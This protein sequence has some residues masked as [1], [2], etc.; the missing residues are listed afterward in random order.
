L[1]AFFVIIA[2]LCLYR[3]KLFIPKSNGSTLI[4]D[5]YMSVEKS[6]SIKGIFILIVFLSHSDDYLT[7]SS[8]TL[9]TT[10]SLVMSIIG[11]AMVSMFLFYSGYGV[12]YSINKKGVGYVKSMPV[13]RI[14]KTLFNFD[15]VILLYFIVENILGNRFGIVK[16]LLSFIGWDSVGNSN[17]YIFDI[18]ILYLIT[19]ISFIIA[20]KNKNLGVVL[21][22]ALS[23]VAI[24]VLHFTKQSWWYDTILCY[25]AGMIFFLMKDNVDNWINKSKINYWIVLALLLVAFAISYKFAYVLVISF[26]KNVIFAFLVVFVTM[27]FGI[28]NKI[29]NFFGKHLFSI[30]ILER[31]PMLI[32][33]NYGVSNKYLFV[34]LSFILTLIISIPFDYLINKVDNWLFKK[35]N[36]SQLSV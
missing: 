21:T 16:L 28:N 31:I 34:I 17:W 33:S 15:I 35:P 30:Y 26:V 7:L 36:K 20:R 11:Q 18:L 32:L 27:K 1:I 14:L 9:D 6:T 25:P 12:I 4:F 2:L 13:N 19:Y 29:L 5:D 3:I 24:V 22:L 23:C 8:S 10:F